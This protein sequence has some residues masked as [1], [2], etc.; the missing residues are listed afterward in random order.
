ME[1]ERDEH[2][3]FMQLVLEENPNPVLCVSHDGKLLYANRGSWMLLDYWKIKIG[4]LVPGEWRGIVQRVLESRREQ[5]MEISIGVKTLLLH[6]VA[7]DYEKGCVNLYGMDVTRRRHVEEKLRLNAQVIDN[8]TEGIMITDTD[9]RIIEINR[10]FTTITG[11]GREEVLGEPVTS[12][13]TGPQEAGFYEGIWEIV[14]IRG[15][16]RGEVWDRKKNGTIYPKWLSVSAVANER[17]EI[18]RFV[19]IFSDITPMKKSDE[20]LYH[21]AHY[22]S[23]TGLANRRQFHDQLGRALKSARRRK[24]GVGV[25]FID[26]DSF[27]EVN[28]TFGHRAGDQLLQEIGTRIQCSVRETDVVARLGGDEFTVILANLRDAESAAPIARKLLDKIAQPVTIGRNEV[29]VTSSIGI[30]MLAED[31]ADPDMLIQN[32]DLAMYRAKAEGKN[33][34]QVF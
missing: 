16:W 29:R 4:D 20:Q 10:A 1:N 32:A 14:R 9:F 26:L 31:V 2:V 27:K 13:H 3:Q 17:G 11:Y 12:L 19:A 24:E 30:S 8:T 33:T 5:E 23:L 6:M 15:S 18:V 25:M 7:L 22:D 34:F 21:M 28:D